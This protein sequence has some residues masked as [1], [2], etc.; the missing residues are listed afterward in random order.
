[1]GL[2]SKKP[3]ELIYDTAECAKKK[4]RMR[5]MFNEAVNEK[6]SF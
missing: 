6:D 1:M 3:K 2:F 4:T 5:E